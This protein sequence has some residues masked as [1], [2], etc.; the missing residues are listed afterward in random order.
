MHSGN[1]TAIIS[2]HPR[3]IMWTSPIAAL[4]QALII[5]AAANDLTGVS[6]IVVDFRNWLDLLDGTDVTVPTH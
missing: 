2:A 5:L 6:K 4:R 1:L 3:R